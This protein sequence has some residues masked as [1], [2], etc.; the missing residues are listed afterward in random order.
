MAKKRRWYDP[1]DPN[2]SQESGLSGETPSDW[3]E[4]VE[5]LN[6]RAGEM[7]SKE[8]VSSGVEP[9]KTSATGDPL[10]INATHTAAALV[11][12]Y[13]R[14]MGEILK[15]MQ[16][17]ILEAKARG[18][19]EAFLATAC[20]VGRMDGIYFYRNPHWL[21][22]FACLIHFMLAWMAIFAF[23]QVLLGGYDY[24]WGEGFF[25][26][27]S[28]L[29]STRIGFWAAI[30]V[31]LA[32]TAWKYED[33]IKPVQLGEYGIMEFRGLPIER[34]GMKPLQ[35]RDWWC[36]QWILSFKFFSMNIIKKA[37]VSKSLNNDIEQMIE[38]PLQNVEAKV[39][40]KIDDEAGRSESLLSGKLGLIEFQCTTNLAMDDGDF[41]SLVLLV[42]TI[43]G[44]DNAVNRINEALI[45]AMRILLCSFNGPQDQEEAI[46]FNSVAAD[47]LKLYVEPEAWAVGVVI[48]SLLVKIQLPKVQRLEINQLN[49]ERI[50]RQK[51]LED[52]KT[53][54][55]DRMLRTTG[56]DNPTQEQ[57]Y[58]FSNDP[59]H[60]LNAEFA[61]LVE[62]INEGKPTDSIK[63][64]AGGNFAMMLAEQIGEVF[65]RGR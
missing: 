6:P 3:H 63:Y 24:F 37:K 1:I 53:A 45:S 49:L 31:P 17:K 48:E 25:S 58:A 65:A 9:I 26:E 40:S 47:I 38:I 22:G 39:K 14:R 11:R 23:C 64:Y 12:D 51:A 57:I 16:K 2:S 18:E 30:L 34:Q 54:F 5:R 28:I 46:A 42:E 13:D 41:R 50:Q 59:R 44:F 52:A 15:G 43:K 21:W 55:M 33:H 19:K 56:I 62:L 7:A 20:E 4:R 10:P 32:Y 8:A 29:Y 36:P 60:Q 27:M 61:T 35:A